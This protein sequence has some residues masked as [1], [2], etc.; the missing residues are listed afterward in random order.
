MSVV[1][2]GTA[3]DVELAQPASGLDAA[4]DGACVGL[5]VDPTV[6]SVSSYRKVSPR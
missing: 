1:I 2:K 6:D 3:I 4:P 5:E